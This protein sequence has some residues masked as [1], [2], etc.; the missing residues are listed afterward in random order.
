MYLSIIIPVW[1]EAAK[2]SDDIKA[3]IRFT[4]SYK[5]A[6]ELIIV[7]DG[8]KDDTFTIAEKVEISGSISKK[9]LTYS[10]HRGKGYAVRRGILESNG[11][12]VMYMDS[13]QNVP[14]KFLERGLKKLKQDNFDIVIGS[15]YLP[16]SIIKK[17][18]VWYRQLT[19]W[20]FRKTVRWYLRLPQHITDTQCGFKIFKG[21]IARD[22]FNRGEI[23]GFVFDLEIIMMALQKPYR[24]YELPIEWTCDR[25]SRLSLVQS[26][27]PIFRDLKKLKKI[28]MI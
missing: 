20:G 14:L 22:L 13:G 1:N 17:S 16:A 25:D 23:D 5:A 27:V 6:V 12:W 21:D 26:L 2:I 3:I 28:Y 11:T 9:V 7:D 24:I 19:S 10:P 18:L 4:E 8:S 15:R